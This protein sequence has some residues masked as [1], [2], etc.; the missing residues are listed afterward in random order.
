MKSSKHM[1]DL[2]DSY[3][4]HSYTHHL[5]LTNNMSLYLLYHISIHHFIDPSYF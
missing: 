1:E 2:E 3:N 5:D 4:E